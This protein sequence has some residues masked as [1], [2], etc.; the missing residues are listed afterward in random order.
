MIEI[1]KLN[2]SID[3]KMILK[4]INFKLKEGN[5]YGLIGKNGSGKSIFF[6][7]FC[8]YINIDSGEIIKDKDYVVRALIERPCFMEDLT[9]A[10][11]ICAIDSKYYKEQDKINQYL[12]MF[13]LLYMKNE[14]VGNYSLGMKQK[15]GIIQVLLDDP[16]VIIL[17]EPFNGLDESSAN[18]LREELLQ[19]KDA[20]KIIL[21]A[22]HIKEDIN[23]LADEI[24][25][26]KN[27]EIVSI[28]NNEKKIKYMKKSSDDFTTPEKKKTQYT[29]IFFAIAL[30]AFAIILACFFRYIFM[31]KIDMQKA[32]I[33][34][35]NKDYEKA[36]IAS[37]EVP[38]TK[39]TK[40][41]EIINYYHSFMI[42]YNTMSLRENKQNALFVKMALD[43][44]KLEKA[45]KDILQNWQ[46]DALDELINLYYNYS[47]SELNIGKEQWEYVYDASDKTMQNKR[48]DK[49][50]ETIK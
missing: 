29:E 25:C 12:Q 15:L 1:K 10:E 28:D 37:Y 41:K 4:N 14:I 19:L 42:P 2:K 32:K 46:K 33:A 38:Y 22:S 8:N 44:L 7:C 17:D 21:I 16:D 3:N 13:N 35:E 23:C 31:C 11:N 40:E 24:I 26:L 30:S 36:Y 49:L 39:F 18:I 5:I 6:K 48:L 20:G 47:E 27:G 9:A 43:D 45:K 34:F 50:M